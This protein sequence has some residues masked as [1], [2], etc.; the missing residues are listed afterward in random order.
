MIL[1][2]LPTMS[3]TITTVVNTSA[4]TNFRSPLDGGNHQPGGYRYGFSPRT[5]SQKSEEQ[6]DV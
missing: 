6:S 3:E 2:G 5:S 1:G 4:S